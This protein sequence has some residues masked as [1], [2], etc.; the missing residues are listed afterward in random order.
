M[1]SL[2]GLMVE[3]G[4]EVT[5]TDEKLYP[6]MSDMLSELEISPFE[7][8]SASNI[9][10]ANPDMAIIG[11]VIRRE[12]A[13]AQEVMRLGIPC[14]SM[15]EALAELFLKGRT[16]AVVAGT[17][18][19]TTTATL[20]AWLLESTGAAPGFLIGGVGLNFGRSYAIGKGPFFVVEGDEYDTAFFD[21]GP[22]FLHYKPQALILTSIEFDHAD[23]YRDLEGVMES[24]RRLIA[25][26]PPDAL[27]VANTDDEN[28]RS[29]IPAAR[30]RAVT[31][32]L[33]GGAYRPTGVE[34][35]GDGTSFNLKGSDV[36]FFI[37]MWGMHNLSNAAGAIALLIESGFKPDAIALGLKSFKGVK[38]RQEIVG[39]VKGVTII[40]DFAH[41]PTAVEKTIESMR[42]RFP[43]RRIW[44]IFE[45]RSNTSRRKIFQ[46]EFK[47]ALATADRVIVAE[48]YRASA[49][50]P[51]ELFDSKEV[52]SAI[53]SAGVD[54]HC[55]P[56][57]EHIVEFVTR[58]VNA[59]DV[60]LVMSNGGFGGMTHKLVS[61]IGKRRTIL[62]QAKKPREAD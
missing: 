10:N 53:A 38:R 37:P 20:L 61:A 2:A 18:G 55:I 5:G 9:K 13:E 56:D 52:A 60:I 39:E 31:Y 51:E 12:N 30:C 41:H 27:L 14:R 15:P 47:K 25:I 26:L 42:L 43:A 4:H 21:K 28:V 48:A 62:S 46:H 36:R 33:D 50:S 45:P 40:D 6:P 24:F 58:G 44:A 49:I 59:G 17:H 3:A 54:A 1:G 29:A 7:G 16:P 8:Y 34:V 57:V 23:I 35:S 32:G 22:K 11:N 19:K